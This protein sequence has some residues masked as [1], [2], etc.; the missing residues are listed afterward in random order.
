MDL[1]ILDKTLIAEEAGGSYQLKLIGKLD[2]KQSN[3]KEIEHT[4]KFE[5]KSACPSTVIG[6]AAVLGFSK[7]GNPIFL[8]EEGPLE[9]T[10]KLVTV[11][12][13]GVSLYNKETFERSSVLARSAK[14][15]RAALVRLQFDVSGRIYF[16]DGFE[17]F[18]FRKNSSFRKV[19]TQKC[20]NK[21]KEISDANQFE[22]LRLK[23]S[24]KA[25]ELKDSKFVLIAENIC[26]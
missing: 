13:Q 18:E 4:L 20:N 24:E 16:L 26:S 9:V 19:E 15:D 17:C 6:T 23:T 8:T 11:G 14:L 22:K 5:G 3:R 25:F 10:S 7:S 12:S 1:N 2:N 21:K